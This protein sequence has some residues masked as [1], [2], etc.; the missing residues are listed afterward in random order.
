MNELYGELLLRS[1]EYLL[2]FILIYHLLSKLVISKEISHSLERKGFLRKIIIQSMLTSEIVMLLPK[3][4][5][6]FKCCVI[7]K[8]AKDR[9]INKSH[10]KLKLK[11]SWSQA[12]EIDWYDGTWFKVCNEMVEIVWRVFSVAQKWLS[13]PQKFKFTQL[14]LL[15]I[16]K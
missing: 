12:G 2:F 14:T 1:W 13:K 7:T 15:V 4:N 16:I 11:Y 10:R 3:L 8:K 6:F 5:T 9:N